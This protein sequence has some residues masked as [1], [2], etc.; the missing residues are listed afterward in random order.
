MLLSVVPKTKYSVLLGFI[1]PKLPQPAVTAIS[2]YVFH[3]R[4]QK[5]QAA[6]STSHGCQVV[7]LMSVP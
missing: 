6:L 3:M 7:S 1:S 4:K 2:V 5:F